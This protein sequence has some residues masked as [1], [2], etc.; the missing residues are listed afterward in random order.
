[1]SGAL[2]AG[3]AAV[4]GLVA[5]G[6]SP[7]PNM[8]YLPFVGQPVAGPG[9]SAGAVVQSVTDPATVVLSAPA[10]LSGVQFLSFGSEPVT[11]AEAMQFCRFEIPADDPVYPSEA[12]FISSL[13]TAARRYA[14]TKLRS[15]LITQTWVLYLDSFPS[16]G[17]YYN[18]AIREIWPSLGAMPSGL[19]FFPGLI[20][21]STGVINIP[22][23]P[24]QG[25]VSV[26]YYDFNNDIQTVPPDLDNVSLGTPSRIQP[27][28]SRVW[29]ISRP[30]I[31]SVM[32]TFRC[33]Y[34]P[35][36]SNISESTKTAIK[37]GVSSWY[38]NRTH[39]DVGSYVVVPETLDAL[40]SIDDPGTYA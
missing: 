23:P 28:Y 4:S 9:I 14:E 32:V 40:L 39:V 7:F 27:Q 2:F 22:M 18:R 1:M 31:D 17:G 15:A 38:E 30:T 6:A 19:G 13:I 34:G 3:S 12:A 29:P 10:T 8:Q 21:N 20:P 16:A 26:S 36:S 33:G 37:Y 35:L 11:L 25:V 5:V 24:C